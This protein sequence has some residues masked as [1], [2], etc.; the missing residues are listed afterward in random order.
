MPVACP[1]PDAPGTRNV[2]PMKGLLKLALMGF[3]TVVVMEMVRQWR[4][5]KSD[6]VPT[7][8]PLADAEPTAAE[9]LQPEDLRVA[10]NSPL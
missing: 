5:R 4:L 3:L 2:A 7:L 1:C 8:H 6:S 10:Q 9:P